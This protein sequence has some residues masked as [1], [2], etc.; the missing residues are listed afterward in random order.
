MM[1]SVTSVDL[2]PG[3]QPL[4]EALAAFE[5]RPAHT[6]SPHELREMLA[7]MAQPTPRPPNVDVT[8]TWVQGRSSKIR[9]RIYK[10]YNSG[11]RPALLYIHGGGWVTGSLESH[12]AICAAFASDVGCVVVAL[13]YALAPEAP[14]PAAFHDCQDVA[15]WLFQSA[16]SLGIDQT[17]IA[18][19]GDS[20][21][22]N[23]SAALCLW[24]R[25][26]DTKHR[27]CLQL[28]LYPVVDDNVDRP[29][30]LRNAKA[31][32]LDRDIM[33]Y[34]L[35]HYL[36]GNDRL[37]A[38]ALPLKAETLSGLPDAFVATVGH[39]PLL[40]EGAVYAQ[41]LVEAGNNCE[42]RSNP[43][44]V[45]GFLKHRRISREAEKE[46][47]VICQRLHRQFYE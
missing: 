40:D 6:L 17:R 28:L 2:D 9:I 19:A 47:R 39:D 38:Y 44:L 45:H 3:L 35:G 41:R 23:L 30:Y 5:T 11:I 14:F 31:P 46:Y 4:L 1:Q 34:C 27:F 32:V 21:G 15:E 29:S 25:D 8:D 33:I 18:V 36:K 7:S 43:F 42:Y 37:N 16:A 12:D 26:T 24:M 10:P 13:D 22:G 20:A